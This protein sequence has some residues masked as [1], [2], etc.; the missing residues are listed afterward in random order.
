MA[1]RA[2]EMYLP[3][4]YMQSEQDF[5]KGRLWIPKYSNFI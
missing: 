1:A 2:I 3:N 5:Q 4:S